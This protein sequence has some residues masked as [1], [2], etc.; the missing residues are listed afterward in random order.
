MFSLA[1]IGGLLLNI[2]AFLMFRGLAFQ[3]I[4]VYIFADICWVFMAVQR[5]DYMG[6]CFI[7]VGMAFGFLAYLKMR[8]GKMHKNLN[9]SDSTH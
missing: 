6:A 4:I 8:S 9:K 2:G 1:M 3:A 7:F 5:E